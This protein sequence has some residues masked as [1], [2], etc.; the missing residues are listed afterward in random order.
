MNTHTWREVL[1]L[2][3]HLERVDRGG[4]NVQV[5]G[6]DGDAPPAAP[7]LPGH[8]DRCGAGAA[9]HTQAA[10]C[11]GSCE[12]ALL[13]L[14]LRCLV[15]KVLLHRA[16]QVAHRFWARGPRVFG[17]P[18]AKGD[19]VG[20]VGHESDGVAIV[21]GGPVAHKRSHDRPVWCWACSTQICGARARTSDGMGKRQQQQRRVIGQVHELDDHERVPATLD[22]AW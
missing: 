16:V 14:Q 20:I 21:Q 8:V 22:A 13:Q 19:A 1:L 5:H 6:G 15:T 2:T 17:G 7:D 3:A 12:Q 11:L 4:W 18:V 10:G 9:E